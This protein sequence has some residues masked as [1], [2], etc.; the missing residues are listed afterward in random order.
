MQKCRKPLQA[1]SMGVDV[2]QGKSTREF[3]SLE[4][5]G[6]LKMRQLTYSHV[7]G[8]EAC[9]SFLIGEI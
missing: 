8:V 1:E 4:I 2:S 5:R 6:D 3:S 9:E 7:V